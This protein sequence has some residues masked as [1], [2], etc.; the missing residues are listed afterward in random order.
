MTTAPLPENTVG[1]WRSEIDLRRYDRSPVLSKAEQRAIR[2]LGLRD[3]RRLRYHNADAPQWTA[4]G[5]LLRPLHDVN[6]SFNTPP[7]MHLR[8]AMNDATAVLLLRCADSGRTYWD[9]TEQDWLN[10]LGRNHKA[11][12][13]QVPVWAEGAVRPFLCGHAYH[14]GGYAGFNQLGHFDRPALA[15]RIFGR[16]LVEEEIK[17]VRTVL[18]GWGYRYGQ[19]HDKGT[20]SVM[21][22]LFL[23]N[24]SPHTSDLTTPLFDRV[25]Q[26]NLLTG[27]G[28]K[29]LYAVQ[30]A[31]AALG[32]CDPPTLRSTPAVV[33]HAG[34]PPVWAEWVERW[35]ATTTMTHR[36]RF[37]SRAALLKAGRWI[38]ADQPL[39]LPHGAGRHAR[40]GSRP[41]TA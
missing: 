21:S 20:P 6:A 38:A 10:L 31:V 32:F 18:T 27:E 14:L 22:Q 25:R 30:R 26:E 29:V 24:R 1:P 16:R 9:W 7:T 35:T 33:G 12:Q 2:E 37:N 34:V 8:R 39:I 4:I 23:L 19:E 3:L 15:C 41:S 28:M 36:S 11:F 5:R 17:H 13:K 40:P